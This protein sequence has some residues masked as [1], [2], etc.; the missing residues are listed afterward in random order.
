MSAQG[1]FGTAFA[2]VQAAELAAGAV[3]LTLIGLNI[4]DGI[5]L[6]HAMRRDAGAAVNPPR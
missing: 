4:R 3:N 5:R 2:L 6:A 1:S